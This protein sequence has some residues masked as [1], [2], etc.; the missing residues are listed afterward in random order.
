MTA[1]SAVVERLYTASEVLAVTG[2]SYPMLDHWCRAGYLDNDT[3]HGHGSRRA[4]TSAELDTMYVVAGLISAGLTVAAAFPIARRIVADDHYTAT[5]ADIF[6]LR[7]EVRPD[8][9]PTET[10]EGQ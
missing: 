4:F 7:I 10:Q 3:A 8:L 1:P 2:V 5:V 6:Q 9:V